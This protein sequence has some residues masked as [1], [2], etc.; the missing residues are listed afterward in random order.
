MCIVIILLMH[1]FVPV[2]D[3]SASEYQGVGYNSR[4]KTFTEP[5]LMQCL[6]TQ[7]QK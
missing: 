2:Q 3:L 1:L 7:E 6:F 5:E 4:T